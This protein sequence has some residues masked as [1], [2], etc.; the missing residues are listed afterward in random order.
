METF[1][2]AAY[3]IL[4]AGFYKAELLTLLPVGLIAHDSVL[5]AVCLS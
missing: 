5:P 1:A 2:A 3:G 4:L